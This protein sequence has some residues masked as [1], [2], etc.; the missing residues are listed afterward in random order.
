VLQQAD[1]EHKLSSWMIE[2]W[3]NSPI[4]Q[5]KEQGATALEYAAASPDVNGE[6]VFS[7]VQV[8]VCSPRAYHTLATHTQDKD[9]AWS[10]H[11]WMHVHVMC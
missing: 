9:W 7:G 5:T 3:A 2:A 1:T 8:H 10:E 6:Y 4:G 11:V